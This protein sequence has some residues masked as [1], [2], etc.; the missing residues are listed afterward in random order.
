[1][2]RRRDQAAAFALSP[3]SYARLTSALALTTGIEAL[4]V[5]RDIRGLS[6]TQAVQVSHWMARA[7]LKQ[8]LAERQSEQRKARTKKTKSGA[9]DSLPR[10]QAVFRIQIPDPRPMLS[11]DSPSVSRSRALS[12]WHRYIPA[13]SIW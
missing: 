4:L 12:N 3:A 1:M 9:A 5:L 6:A 13:N 10:V 2:D 7:L 8:S 11:A